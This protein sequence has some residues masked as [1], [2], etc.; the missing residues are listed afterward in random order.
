MPSAIV[1]IEPSRAGPPSASEPGYA[2]APVGLDPDHA[3]VG[4]QRLDRDRHAG[5]QAAPAGGHQHGLHLGH[6]LEDLQAH[7]AL[8]GDDVGVVERVDEDGTGLLGERL[9]GG[10]HVLEVPAEAHL[11]AVARGGRDLGDRRPVGHEHG[12]AGAEHL[13][14]ER[15]ALG[16]VAGGLPRPRRARV[17]RR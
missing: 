12:G 3:D 14:G 10:Q 8:P 5:Q 6:L 4:A 9:R 16:V 1:F 11:R 2:A 17:P 13:R 7:G 15:D